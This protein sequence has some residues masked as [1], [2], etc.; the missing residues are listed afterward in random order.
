MSR[1]YLVDNSQLSAEICTAN[2]NPIAVDGKLSN[3]KNGN[4]KRCCI[5]S[6]ADP[7]QTMAQHS[8]RMRGRE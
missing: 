7:S 3:I 1:L 4:D 8:L 5:G 6:M 2:A